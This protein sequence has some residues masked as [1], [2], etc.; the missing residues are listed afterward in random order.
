MATVTVEEEYSGS[1]YIIKQITI[2]GADAAAEQVVIEAAE[3]V[4]PNGNQ[5]TPFA[6]VVLMEAVWNMND[7]YDTVKLY[8]DD[9]GND[10]I[11]LH[12]QGDGSWSAAGWGGKAPRDV[13][14]LEDEDQEVKLD[15]TEDGAENAGSAGN[16]T[17]VFK[18]KD[19]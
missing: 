5:A 18:L 7:G 17:L 19:R 12:M 14:G 13:A 6:D 11:I 1:R 9:E 3:A 4:S 8:W 10:R 2:T 16:I 15:V